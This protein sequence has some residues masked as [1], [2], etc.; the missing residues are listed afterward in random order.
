MGVY[1]LIQALGHDIIKNHYFI[2]SCDDHLL[3]DG[4]R[5]KGL[6]AAAEVEEVSARYLIILP[7]YSGDSLWVPS[8]SPVQQKPARE[9]GR[10]QEEQVVTG[11]GGVIISEFV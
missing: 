7:L 9:E 3:L 1:W 11:R 6:L 8:H 4:R 5:K 10:K 2:W